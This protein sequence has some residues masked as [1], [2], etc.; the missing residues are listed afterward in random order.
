[1]LIS[2]SFKVVLA[3]S[4]LLT[5]VSCGEDN[6]KSRPAPEVNQVVTGYTYKILNSAG[7]PAQGKAL[8]EVGSLGNTE[9]IVNECNDK[10]MNHIDRTSTP[11]SLS[12]NGDAPQGD[13]FTVKVLDCETMQGSEKTVGFT[14][15][16]SGATAE[17]VI[18]L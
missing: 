10:Q 5:L 14:V 4:M 6:K 9:V 7:F 15:N 8:V 12:F 1:M 11:E 2:K 3:S 13:S 17:V 18:S 16:K